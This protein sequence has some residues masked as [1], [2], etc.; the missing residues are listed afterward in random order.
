MIHSVGLEGTAALSPALF[1]AV[2]HWG[3]VRWRGGLH[4]DLQ[5]A[6]A[7]LKLCHQGEGIECQSDY[8]PGVAVEEP[9]H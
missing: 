2:Q 4:T 5:V 7:V 6:Q 8:H 9:P 1:F 3:Q